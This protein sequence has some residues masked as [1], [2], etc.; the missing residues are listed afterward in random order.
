MTYI[1]KI[2]EPNKKRQTIKSTNTENLNASFLKV[3]GIK[4]AMF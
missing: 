4:T 3:M 1:R 2:I